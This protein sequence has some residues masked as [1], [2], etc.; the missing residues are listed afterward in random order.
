MRSPPMLLCWLVVCLVPASAFIIQGLEG[1]NG[2]EITHASVAGGSHL[3]LIGTNLG[4]A[5]APP[6]VFIGSSGRCDVQP[7]TS[8]RNRLH[9]I[10]RR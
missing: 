5:F 4:S 8:T 9:C 3:Y 7:F 2:T 10:W 1:P 6:T